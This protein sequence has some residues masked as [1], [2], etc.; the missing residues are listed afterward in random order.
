MLRLSLQDLA[1]K[2]KVMKI[3]IGTSIENALSLALDP[4][5]ALNVQ[6][7]VSALVE[8]KALTSNEE[9]TP[10]GRH[11]SRL[12]LDVHMA[13]FLLI[14]TLFKCLDPALTIAAAL[15]SKSPFITPF[16][17]EAEAD[18]SK[19]SFKT[20]D[21]DF[22]SIANAY[23]AWRRAVAQNYGRQFCAKAFLS[24]Q[25]LMQIEELRQ[26]YMAY[27]LD[28][29]FAQIDDETR[30]E[31]ARNKFRA[32]SGKPR[33]MTAPADLDVNSN[34]MA[35]L[36]AAISAGLYPKLL[37]IEPKSYQ[38]KTIGNNQP[39]SIHPSSVNFRMRLSELPRGANHLV[40][41]TIMSTKKLYAWETG[42]VDDRGVMV[43][44]GEADWKVSSRSRVKWSAS[45]N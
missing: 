33:F 29:G 15:N 4:P 32:G 35:I 18:R 9:I 38:L 34:S 7:A 12:P 42:A 11:L 20:G 43:L 16:G 40:Y 27:L 31:M 41:F 36:N 5:L 17:R 28:S 26:Q 25:T 14:A 6:R 21:S 8:V 1:L 37:S 13:K 39:V 22:F 44:C 24:Q 2:L 19:A 23:N 10:L 30:K 45:S 3:R